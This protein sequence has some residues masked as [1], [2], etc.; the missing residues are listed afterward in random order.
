MTRYEFH[1][2]GFFTES[3]IAL[4]SLADIGNSFLVASAGNPRTNMGVPAWFGAM[5]CDYDFFADRS[6]HFALWIK[7]IGRVGKE[8]KETRI[9]NNSEKMCAYLERPG[10]A[11]L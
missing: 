6:G 1:P 10:F 11:D 4:F 8:R 7:G 3:A 9:L 5:P 2:F